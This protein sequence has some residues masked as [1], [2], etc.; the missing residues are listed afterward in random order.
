MSPTLVLL[1]PWLLSL[2]VPLLLWAFLARLSW[3]SLPSVR[4]R[5]VF[6]DR[7]LPAHRPLAGASYRLPWLIVGLLLVVA[8]AQP[9]WQKPSEKVAIALVQTDLQLVIE[10]SVST[11]LLEA[12]GRSRLQQAQQFIQALLRKR[13]EQSRTGLVVFADEVYPVLPLTQ[14]SSVLEV[15]L[16][17]L[18]AALAGREDAALLEAL[19]FASWQLTQQATSAFSD[20][21]LLTDGAHA[22]TRGQL[23]AV[24]DYMNRH[25]IRLHL[26]LLGGDLV[27]ESSS[28]GL[29][30]MPR[31]RAL[32]EQ[33][34][35]FNIVP[36]VIE[37]TAGLAQLMAK[38]SATI[39]ATGES[40]ALNKVQ[41]VSLVSYVLVLALFV[42]L[43]AW[44]R[45]FIHDV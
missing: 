12:D 28:S 37:D 32:V 8:L 13:S 31:Q 45:E 36:I 16:L 24:V 27:P 44:W 20:V 22:P 3:Q 43:A 14:D 15:M 40:D 21:L 2:A 10:T 6:V 38:L 26:V 29:L 17:R 39:A 25:Q 23:S 30:Y 9:V 42:W 11:L 1:E 4:V 5:H 7:F 35:P 41:Q 33:L 18:D 34:A 19:Q